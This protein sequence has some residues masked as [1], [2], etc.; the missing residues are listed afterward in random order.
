MLY[1]LSTFSHFWLS[2]LLSFSLRSSLSASALRSRSIMECRVEEQEETVC[3]EL[4]LV[5]FGLLRSIKRLSPPM[6]FVHT[7]GSLGP[8][9]DW[10]KD[11]CWCD[12]GE[13]KALLLS[14]AGAEGA[15]GPSVASA[16]NLLPILAPSKAEIS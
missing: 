15:E 16:G 8:P 12:K 7:D 11:V 6:G 3:L 9:D 1:T 14:S 10:V 13:G 5:D 4:R 2:I